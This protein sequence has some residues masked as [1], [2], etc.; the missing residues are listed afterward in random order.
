M[1]QEGLENLKSENDVQDEMKKVFDWFQDNVNRL[2]NAYSHLEN[3]F[4]QVKEELDLKTSALQKATLQN[5]LIQENLNTLLNSMKPGVVMIDE[6]FHITVL[7]QSAEKLLNMNS[8]FCEGKPL[9]EVF[10]ESCILNSVLK[11]SAAAPLEMIEAEK[12][13]IL[14]QDVSFPASIKGS[15]IIGYEDK[16]IGVVVTFTDLTNLKKMEEEIQ[17]HKILGAL[18]EMAATVAHEIR[19]PLGGIGGYAGLLA[20]DLEGDDPKKRLVDKIILGVSSLNKI[21]S[22]LLYY[23]RKT[24]TRIV[25]IDLVDF[26]E[27]VLSYVSI[28][29][30]KSGKSIELIRDWSFKEFQMELDPEKLQQVLLNLLLNAIQA[31]E[32]GGV[33]TFSLREEGNDLIIEI[34][35]SGKGMD[36]E[37]LKQIFNPF[38]TTKEQGTGLGLAIVKKIIDLHHGQISVESTVDSGTVFRIFLPK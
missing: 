28:E 11:E 12:R 1:S 14:N 30:E 26:V 3:Q 4:N 24:E 15:A 17:Q 19:N 9:G 27:G 2:E 18:G 7:N 13:I 37:T 21:V 20:R 33:I 10:P 8:D 35:D 25:S 32:L 5:N 23:T 6:S 22:N 31:I 34:S 36:E 38:Y 29:I 16:V